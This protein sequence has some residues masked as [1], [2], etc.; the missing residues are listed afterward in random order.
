MYWCHRRRH[1]PCGI[2]IKVD[3]ILKN[4]LVFKKKKEKKRHH[5]LKG[6]IVAMAYVT[7]SVVVGIVIVMN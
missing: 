1:A 5:F 4:Q 7:G 6:G 2:V 3:T